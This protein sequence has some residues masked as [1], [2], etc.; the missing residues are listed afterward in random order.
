MTNYSAFLIVLTEH[1]KEHFPKAVSSTFKVLYGTGIIFNWFRIRRPFYLREN[2]LL[3]INKSKTGYLLDQL[4]LITF[5]QAASLCCVAS[6]KGL[7]F[8]LKQNEKNLNY[9]SKDPLYHRI[10]SYELL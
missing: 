10:H 7:Q 8:L 5:N 3:S 1:S 9:S 4:S 6:L 2:L